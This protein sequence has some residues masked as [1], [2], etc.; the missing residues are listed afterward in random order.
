MAKRSATPWTPR[1]ITPGSL[2]RNG[3]RPL[4]VHPCPA[5]D[6]A[7]G[8]GGGIRSAEFDRVDPGRALRRHVPYDPDV[9]GVRGWAVAG[10][11][12]PKTALWAHL[13]LDGLRSLLERRDY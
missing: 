13:D 9:K 7:R 1:T 6:Q 8:A 10:G 12:R 2:S 3:P 11:K 5:C 4:S